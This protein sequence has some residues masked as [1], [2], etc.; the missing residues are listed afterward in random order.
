[1]QDIPYSHEAAHVADLIHKVGLEESEYKKV[2]EL[3][4]G[5]KR[6]LSIAI[7]MVGNP[8]LILLDEPTTGLDPET[9][10]KIWDIINDQKHGKSI[11]LTTHSIKLVFLFTSVYME[12]ADVLC[13]RIGIVAKGQLVC[14]GTQ[15]HLKNKYGEGYHL[16][17]TVKPENQ[18]RVKRFATLPTCH[19]FCSFVSSMYKSAKLES[20]YS[21]ILSYQISRDEVSISDL[22][23]IMKN[24]KDEY[25]VGNCHLIYVI[26][27]IL[28]W[29]IS[30]TSLEEVFLN[31]IKDE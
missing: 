22:V 9:R 24:K 19:L 26:Y 3:S 8:K 2:G 27:G 28:E 13:S 21:G 20:A 4:G 7:A 15:L 17:V 6:R 16:S 1:M 11:V 29:G 30:Q 23:L 18:D 25:H 10:R 14:I 31:I 12:E 5:M